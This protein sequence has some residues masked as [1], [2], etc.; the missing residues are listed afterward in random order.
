VIRVLAT[1]RG[2]SPLLMNRMTAGDWKELA[3]AVSPQKLMMPEERRS[4]IQR[5]RD[6]FY[7]K[8][9]PLLGDFPI[10]GTL[11]EL[12]SAKLYR[13]EDDRIG[14]PAV[15][16]LLCL[17]D[18]STRLSERDRRFPPYSI[19]TSALGI[20]EPFLPFKRGSEWV[21]DFRR[22]R[23]KEGDW[24]QLCRPKIQSW[25]LSCTIEFDETEISE[26]AVQRLFSYAGSRQGLCDFRPSKGGPFGRFEL[27]GWEVL[28]RVPEQG[29]SYV[30]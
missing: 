28:E 18:A 24:I 27:V 12:A 26:N 14:L 4:W 20:Q 6:F 21:P 30:K 2:T 3:E 10:S 23:N 15:N 7:G 19:F 5:L 1:I 8:R 16:L 9:G 17:R 29:F 25:E 13:D 22:G 11:E